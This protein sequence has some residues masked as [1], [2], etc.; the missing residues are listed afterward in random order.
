[1]EI[2]SRL[3]PATL[4]LLAF[5]Q[6]APF[7]Y[8][9]ALATNGFCGKQYFIQLQA[10]IKRLEI[11]LR[12]DKIILLLVHGAAMDIQEVCLYSHLVGMVVGHL[13]QL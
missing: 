3:E 11:P 10:R 4:R 12:C 13:H 6:L 5:D 2:G 7:I 8:L 9:N 1:M